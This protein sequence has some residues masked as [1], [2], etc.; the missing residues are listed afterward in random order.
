MGSLVKTPSSV[1]LVAEARLASVAGVGP[2]SRKRLVDA[3]GDARAVLRASV[4]DLCRVHGIGPRTAR[5]IA[6]APPE[7]ETRRLLA[8]AADHGIDALAIDGDEYPASLRELY[9]P[10]AVLYARGRLEPIDGR[11][12]AI[13]G[14]RRATRYGL[15]QAEALAAGLARAGVTVVSGLARGVDAAAHRACLAAGGRTLAVLGGGLLRIYPPEHARLAD[16]VAASGALLAEAPPHMPPMSGSFPQRNRVIS[17]LSLGVV[18]IEAAERSG[19]LITAR[20]AAEQGRDAFAVP[21]PIDSP[22]SI[23]CHRLI[24]EGAKLVVTVDDILE[25]LPEHSSAATS[26]SGPAKISPRP[27]P[28]DPVERAVW[29]AAGDGPVAI[30]DVIARTELA[31]PRV[32]AAIAMMETR[33]VLKRVS[34]ATVARS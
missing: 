20:H 16:E 13:V 1:D 22:Q 7:E 2:L 25:E 28:E 14:T 26:V 4:D 32:L 30:D 27:A 15:R 19:A 10:P 5:A 21:G 29:D 6:S 9:D 24:Q 18:V 3:F 34:G 17:G 11:A 33:G 8:D 23:G 31:T 12:V